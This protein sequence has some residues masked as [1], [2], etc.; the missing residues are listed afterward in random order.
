MTVTLSQYNAMG[1]ADRA[2]V[3][4]LIVD[5]IGDV[6]DMLV[7]DKGYAREDQAASTKVL[8]DRGFIR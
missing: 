1:P 4:K 2:L 3:T 6:W 8:D 7:R 5:D